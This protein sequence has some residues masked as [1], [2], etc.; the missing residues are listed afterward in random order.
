MRF[1]N[2]VFNVIEIVKAYKDWQPTVNARKA[3]KTVLS[4]VPDEYLVGLRRIIM[5]NATGLNRSRRRKKTKHR[6]QTRM[7][8]EALGN[9][10]QSWQGQPAYIEIFVD[11]IIAQCPRAMRV[12]PIRDALFSDVIFHEIGHHVHTTRAREFREREEVADDWALRI[13]SRY[14]RTRAWY[15]IPLVE[16]FGLELFGRKINRYVSV[17][18]GLE[19]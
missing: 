16:L 10:H 3:V 9:Y 1:K 15:L 12:P 14:F 11:N 6:G 4:S 17:T 19:L 13:G 8:K 7:S 5:T 18:S 2:T